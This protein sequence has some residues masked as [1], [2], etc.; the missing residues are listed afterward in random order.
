MTANS[1]PYLHETASQTAGPFLHIGL[2]PNQAGLDVFGTEFSNVL[3]GPG[4]KGQRI[5]IEGHVFDGFGAAA[6]D[7]VLE[8]W[9]ANAAGRYHHPDDAR[10][11]REIDPHFRG[12]GRAGT[13]FKTGLFV[14]ETIKPGPVNGRRGHRAMAPHI[15]FWLAARGINIGLHTRMYFSDEIEANTQ[16]PVLRIVE[17]PERQRTL[18][19]QRDQSGAD[20]VYRF[21]IRLQGDNETVFFDV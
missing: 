9:Q 16:D 3:V 15:N 14:F 21:D 13:D 8:I 6:N 19:A 12:W 4:T 17:H 20:I 7:V 18:I 2:L 10:S 11:A 5:R 1:A